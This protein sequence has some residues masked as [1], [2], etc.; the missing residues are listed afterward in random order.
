MHVMAAA[1]G[2][3]SCWIQ[4]RMRMTQDGRR[5]ESFIQDVLGVPENYKLEAMLSL[6]MPGEFKAGHDLC[7]LPMEKVH[8]GKF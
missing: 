3:G 5:T 2:I 1:L 7:D 4:G 6:G 8:W